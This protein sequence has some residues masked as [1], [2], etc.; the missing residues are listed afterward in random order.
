MLRY[1]NSA[2]AHEAKLCTTFTKHLIFEPMLNF[3][4]KNFKVTI[5]SRKLLKIAE[6]CMKKEKETKEKQSPEKTEV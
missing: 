5:S 3:V 2:C 4:E 6:L 1:N